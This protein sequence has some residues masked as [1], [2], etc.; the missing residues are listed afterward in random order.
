M[1]VAMMV[2]TYIVARRR[3]FPVS[4]PVPAREWPRI[5]G[6][7]L[8]P[9]TLPVVLL[10]GIYSGAFTPTEA[11][12]VGAAYAMLL[13]GFVYHTL[14]PR[15]LYAVFLESLRSSAVVT[16][17]IAGAFTVNYAVATEQIPAAI[18]A[19]LDGIDI[20]RVAFLLLI[21]ALFLAL[22]CLL[23]ATTMLLVIVPLLLPTLQVLGVDLV[24]F[25][26][27]IVVNMMIGLITPPY[28][29]LLFVLS[30]LTKIP[31]REIIAESWVFI[32]ALVAALLA[33]TLVSELVL[34][35]PQTMGYGTR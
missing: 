2:A 24:H 17:I 29:V 10:G 1:A 8:L 32:A 19:W 20:S 6:S 21:N 3:G 34:W 22:G 13:A 28:G 4:E 23:D 25:G 18:A 15:T 30:G 12:A 16:L 14:G 33:M 27:M 11:A 26:V 7:A 35:L 31:T 5:F 9:L